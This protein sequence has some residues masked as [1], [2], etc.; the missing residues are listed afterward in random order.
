[1]SSAIRV[2][3]ILLISPVLFAAAPATAP[4]PAPVPPAAAPPAAAGPLTKH[5]VYRQLLAFNRRTTV[6]AYKKVG[7]RDPKW[8]AAAE[9]FLDAMSRHFAAAH[10][11]A[12]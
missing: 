2:V 5:D 1:M 11:E 9:Q 4:A 7:R 8:D 3:G 12:H 6:E 10:M